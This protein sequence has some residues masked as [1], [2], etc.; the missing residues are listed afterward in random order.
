MIA[1][2]TDAYSATWTLYQF[3]VKFYILTFQR[4]DQDISYPSGPINCPFTNYS[5][6]LPRYEII[7]NFPSQYKYI[8]GSGPTIK[9]F[10]LFVNNSI[11]SGWMF[12][13]ITGQLFG[14]LYWIKI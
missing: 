10:D 7:I 2:S 6:H 9:S 8:A 5:Q 4:N 13:T 1:S 12:D 14:T 3:M 11:I